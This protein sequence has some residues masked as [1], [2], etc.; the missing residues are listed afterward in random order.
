[1]KKRTNITF[2]T[3]LACAAIALLL[4]M[5]SFALAKPGKG[6]KAA[7]P[8]KK[9]NV[10]AVQTLRP[11]KLM[12]E[13]GLALVEVPEGAI[14]EVAEHKGNVVWVYGPSGQKYRM[15]RQDVRAM[16]AHKIS[17]DGY[18][19]S[20]LKQFGFQASAARVAAVMQSA[21]PEKGTELTIDMRTEW[22]DKVEIEMAIK[23][24][25]SVPQYSLMA[26]WAVYKGWLD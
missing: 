20:Q 16:P 3:V 8:P 2:T 18:N 13:S 7:K 22:R 11:A 10:H 15:R 14:F 1:M 21:Y 4:L 19:D 24:E 6:G 12:T 17:M 26:S 23:M 9:K 5:G 25:I